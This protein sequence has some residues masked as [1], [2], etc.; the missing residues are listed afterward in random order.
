MKMNL[1]LFDDP[2]Y[3]VTVYKDEHMSAASASPDT[4]VAKDATV[5]LTLTPA[6]GYEVADVEVIS[7]GVTI[8]E[9]DSV[10][11]TM[12]T[13]NVVLNVKSQ[14]DNK[15]K[16]TENCYCCLNNGAPVLLRRNM[17]LVYGKNGAIIDIKGTPTAVTLSADIIANLL[18][19]GVIVKDNPAWHGEPEPSDS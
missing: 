6:S 4:G 7:G 8:Y 17:E 13:A 9:G 12:G 2:T 15:Y 1:R 19:S 18:E 11:F 16:V 10:T 14:A 5:T 3:T